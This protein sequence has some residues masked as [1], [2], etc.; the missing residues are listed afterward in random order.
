MIINKRNFCLKQIAESGQC[1]RMNEISPNRFSLVAF[2]RH[3]ELI[4]LDSETVEFQCGEQE[5]NDI[6]RD[7]FDIDYDYEGIVHRLRQGND[8]FLKQAVEF[9][10]GIRILRQ[11][12]FE[13]LI[14]FIIS[15]NKNIPAIKKCIEGICKSYGQRLIGPEGV[16]YYTFPDAVS[17]S[18][19]KKE[20]LRELSLGYRD[21][22][23]LSAASAVADGTLDLNKLM[24]CGYEEAVAALKSI[25][26]IGDKVANC[27]ALYGFHYIDA[28][29]IDVWIKK[30]LNEVYNNKF[31]PRIYEG[32]AGII[33]QYM[34]YY[35]RSHQ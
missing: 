25:R 30:V 35:M 1:F 31:D 29:P 9:G 24:E 16:E 6:W 10:G 34:F 27:I 4:Q 11:E 7:Y 3:I 33:Q 28:F 5:F 17:L 15:Q 19:A 12:P 18:L 26:G 22:Y 21:D 2:G 8:E 32:Y 14:S 23:I 20:E 13:I